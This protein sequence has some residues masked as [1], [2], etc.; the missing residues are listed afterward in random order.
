M[1]NYAKLLEGSGARGHAALVP[2]ARDA[3]HALYAAVREHRRERPEAVEVWAA[4]V[5]LGP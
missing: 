4:Y 2:T 3:A 5:H 1:D